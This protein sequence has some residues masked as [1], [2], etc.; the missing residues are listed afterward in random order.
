MFAVGNSEIG[1]KMSV[2][3]PR[4]FDEQTEEKLMK[5]TDYRTLVGKSTSSDSQ[6]PI[7]SSNGF[8]NRFI[9]KRAIYR[10]E[11]NTYC[12]PIPAGGRLSQDILVWCSFGPEELGMFDFDLPLSKKGPINMKESNLKASVAFWPLGMFCSQKEAWNWVNNVLRIKNP[13]AVFWNIRVQKVSGPI[14]A[15]PSDESFTEVEWT[16]E[17]HK[18]M[19]STN[20]KVKKSSNALSLRKNAVQEGIKKKQ[21]VNEALSQ[22]YQE[23]CAMETEIRKKHEEDYLSKLLT[24]GIDYD[25]ITKHIQAKGDIRSLPPSCID[26]Y[27]Q[28]E[29]FNANPMDPFKWIIVKNEA[30]Q[31]VYLAKQY[32]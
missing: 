5:M 11:E 15:I 27:C 25:I 20:D 29:R 32:L 1:K 8:L 6:L 2:I 31:T 28:M 10:K 12:H 26:L 4:S 23:L 30:D 24:Q 21:A 13:N 19:Q 14:N 7:N 3:I 17:Y 18:I 9:S 16:D 22:K